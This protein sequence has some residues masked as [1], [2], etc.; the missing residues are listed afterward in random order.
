MHLLVLGLNYAPEPVGIGPFTAGMAEHLA[1]AGHDVTVVA[2]RPYYPD[3]RPLSGSRRNWHRT[4]EKGVTVIR[5]PHY[6]PRK[7]GG[8]K[9]LVHHASFALA[10]FWPMIRTARSRPDVVIAIAPSLMALPVAKLA[11]RLARAPLWLHVQDFETEAAFATG[12]LGERSLLGRMAR[13]AERRLLAM[14]GHVSTISPQMRAR[15]IAKGVPPERTSELRNWADDAVQAHPRDSVGA[16]RSEWGVGSRKLALYSG[17]IANKQGLEIV[18]EAARLLEQRGDLLFAICGQGP[19]RARLE[20]QAQGAS[21]ILFCDLQP[22]ER[23]DELLTAADIHLLPQVAEAADLVL[24]SKLGNMLASGRPVV[25]CAAPDTGIAA[26][27]SGSG[28]AVPPGD[29][30]AMARA[31][32]AL[33]DDPARATALGEAAAQA[34]AQEWSRHAVLQRFMGELERLAKGRAT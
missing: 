18:I 30:Q 14:A 27:I 15:L 26:E 6:I 29:P 33:A 3:W 5:C 12:L 7:P 20:A 21:N 4:S 31:I 28:I 32:V 8:L 13:W 22:R 1:A 23:L 24:P 11:A 9:R 19:N 17:N 25:A 16:Y 2:G 34:A 10:S